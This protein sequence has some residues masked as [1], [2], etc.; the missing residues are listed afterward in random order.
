MEDHAG[1]FPS[2]NEGTVRTAYQPASAELELALRQ[3]A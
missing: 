1:E 2:R 3:E